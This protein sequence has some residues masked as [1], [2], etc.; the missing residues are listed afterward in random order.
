MSLLESPQAQALLDEAEITARDIQGCEERLADF[1]E[2]FLP[3]FYRKEQR[4]NA[5]VVVRGLLSDLDRKTCEPIAYREDRERKPIQFFVGRGRWN[6][7]AVM[8][9]VRRHVVEEIGTSHGVIIFD[10]SGFPKKGDASCGVKRQWCGRL[11]K[12]EN[13]QIGVFMAYAS[14]EGF[15]PLDR[16]LFL[17]KEWAADAER[18]EKCCVPEDVTYQP[19]WQIARDM[20]VRH[21]ASIP[22]R[23]VAGDDEFGRVSAFRSDL[24]ERGE[25][26]VLDVPANTLVRDLCARRPRRRSAKTRRR[27]VPFV[28]ASA[29]A[30]AQPRPRWKRF[31]VRAG[32]KG[33]I[34]VEAIESRVRTREEGRVGP[35]ERLVV[36]RS[37]G[38]Q[39]RVWYVL[40]NADDPL[41]TIV[42]VHGCRHQIEQVFE[43]AKGEAGLGHYEVRSWIGWHHHMTLSLLALWFLHTEARRLEK[44]APGSDGAATAAAL[45]PAAS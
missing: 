10:P 27:E 29:W 13:C 20:L 16:R 45:L 34:E 3:F 23:W 41:A 5:G 40:T 37:R 8:G 31:T 2:R 25:R 30:E 36:I 9:E 4:E 32:E 33:P 21:G 26:Y 44:K 1:V 28:H 35:E 17:P 42:W 18:R 6:D 11:G 43:E 7:D 24:R 39:P 38:S 22:H 15:G 14:T 12:V 19:T